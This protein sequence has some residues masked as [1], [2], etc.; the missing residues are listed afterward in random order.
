MYW[1]MECIVVVQYK[2][3][4]VTITVVRLRFIKRNAT[5]VFF[6]LC[7]VSVSADYAV[8]ATKC[9]FDFLDN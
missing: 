1:N 4:T 7:S 9:F 8:A 2:E 6:M 5:T 3:I